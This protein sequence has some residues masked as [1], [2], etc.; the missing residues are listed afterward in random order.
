M[1]RDEPAHQPH[2]APQSVLALVLFAV[3]LFFAGM[4]TKLRSPSKQEVLLVLGW[5]V[6][7]GAAVWVATF[8]VTT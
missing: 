6:F 8:P 7:L 1:D 3:A 5:V 2:G 4:A